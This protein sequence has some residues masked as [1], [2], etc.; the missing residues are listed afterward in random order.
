ML[1]RFN[2]TAVP[3]VETMSNETLILVAYRRSPDARLQSVP[4]SPVTDADWPWSPFPADVSVVVL[5]SVR[6][7]DPHRRRVRQAEAVAMTPL[8]AGVDTAG[9]IA[10]ATPFVAFWAMIVYWEGGRR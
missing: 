9:A 8:T 3:L 5:P 7:F 2:A 1:S 4:V 6:T 10:V